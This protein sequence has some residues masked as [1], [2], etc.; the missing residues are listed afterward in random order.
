MTADKRAALIE[1]ARRKRAAG[2]F[3]RKVLKRIPLGLRFDRY[4][5]TCGHSVG[6]LACM[7]SD[8]TEFDCTECAESWVKAGL[9][10]G[11]GRKK[12]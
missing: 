1:E 3:N 11:R 4:H 6:L 10:G 7:A 2:E 5:L 8:V 12:T 9:A